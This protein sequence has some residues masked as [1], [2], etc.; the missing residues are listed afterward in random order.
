MINTF[1]I[2][3]SLAKKRCPYDN[4]VAEAAYKI[5]KIEFAFN[6]RFENFE[7]LKQE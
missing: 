4:A 6:R 2:K 1:G 5:V 7:K 3:R